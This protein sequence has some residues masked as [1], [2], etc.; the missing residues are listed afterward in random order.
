MRVR[1]SFFLAALLLV[2]TPAS[3]AL[4]Q[5]S[6]WS[7][8]EAATLDQ[9]YESLKAAPNEARARA[10]A[11]AI[12]AIWTRPDN[13]AAATRMAEILEKSGFAGPASQMPLIEALVADYPDYPEAWNLRATA[14][15]FRGDTAGA[16]EDIVETLKRE[17]SHFGALAGRALIL[18]EMG[19]SDEAL[20]AITAALA[21]HPFLSERGLFPELAP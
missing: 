9:L 8:S 18:H 16:L 3:A 10:I 6:F 17:P 21:V 1:P 11:D 20:A 2:T 5:S 19:R 15:F 7:Q 13:T 4:A 14:R 12:W